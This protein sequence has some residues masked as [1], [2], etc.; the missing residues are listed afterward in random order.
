MGAKSRV[1]INLA[2]ILRIAF[3]FYA[4]LDSGCSLN[5]PLADIQAGEPAGPRL[6]LPASPSDLGKGRPLQQ[7]KGALVLKNVGNDLLRIEKVEA[8]CG[9]A[10]LGLRQ[11]EIAPG[12][13]VVVDIA[14]RLSADGSP[15]KLPI[16][17]RSNDP[18]RPE[19]VHLVVA[20]PIPPALRTSPANTVDL[21][22]FL[23]GQEP[24]R[25]VQVLKPDGTGWPASERLC[26]KTTHGDIQVIRARVHVDASMPD[27]LALDIRPRAGL[28]VGP[29]SDTLLITPSGGAP[30]VELTVLGTV[31]PR[32]QIVPNPVYFGTLSGG[33]QTF[34]RIIMLKRNDG[35]SL[36]GIVRSAGCNALQIDETQPSGGSPLAAIRRFVLT[37]RPE[38]L[39]RDAT[40][41]KLQL[42]LDGESTPVEVEVGF[43]PSNTSTEEMP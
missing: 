6:Q 26:V 22:P 9:C 3:V 43:F 42:W 39:R 33:S 23:V 30:D 12:D 28:P 38:L 24:T 18:E 36:S 2:T 37:L 35:K 10:I 31:M 1:S 14:V 11:N 5:R 17:I 13:Q 34:Q 40:G 16:R 15:L 41:G 4:I 32:V 21:G 8:S 20:E 27:V 25:R 7:L 19:V 29:F